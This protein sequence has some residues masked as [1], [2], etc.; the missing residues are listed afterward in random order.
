VVAAGCIGVAGIE[1]IWAEQAP[2]DDAS[3]AALLARP[4][5]S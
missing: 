1:R 2:V 4:T 5:G 3:M